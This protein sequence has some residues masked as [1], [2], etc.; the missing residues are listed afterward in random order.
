MHHLRMQRGPRLSLFVTNTL[1]LS[2]LPVGLFAHAGAGPACSAADLK[3]AWA[4]QPTGINTF[5]P[6][7]GPLAATGVATVSFPFC[8][9]GSY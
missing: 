7:A 9:D 1:L 6:V 3:G 2:A 8:L 4:A 5:G